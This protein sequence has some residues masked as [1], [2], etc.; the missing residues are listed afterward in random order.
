MT[1]QQLITR[2]AGY[3]ANDLD[4]YWTD[5]TTPTN[6]EVVSALN[7][8]MRDIAL[9]AWLVEPSLT[10]TL[11]AG[12]YT[13]SLRDTGI[14]SKKALK[15]LRVVINNIPLTTADGRRRGL[16]SF[17]E[18][19]EKYPQWR[20]ADNST[21][22]VAVQLGPN[23]IL[24]PPP[25]STVVSAGENYIT[26]LRLPADLSSASLS[27]SPDLPEE[28]HEGLAKVAAAKAADP[29]ATEGHQDARIARLYQQGMAMA[30]KVGA[31]NRKMWSDPG[32]I[33]NRNLNYLYV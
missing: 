2:V 30:Q 16:W 20:G 6:A 15:V 24:Y 4:G 1:T 8:A 31:E 11:T 32:T 21:P 12:T 18:L 28:L 17:Q 14:V 26:A 33:R 25:T 9:E 27:A 22:H 5:S 19:E 3:M 29:A 10:L 23:L 7:D 13:Y